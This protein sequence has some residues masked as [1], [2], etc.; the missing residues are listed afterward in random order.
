[1]PEPA[2]AAIALGS[3]LGDRAHNL[4]TALFHLATL[5]SVTAVSSFHDTAPVGY[6]DQP[7][8][9]NAAALLRTEL[10]PQ[11]LLDRLLAIEQTMGRIRT[12][13]P[14]KGPR[15]IDLDLLLYDMLVLETPT[16]TLPHPALHERLFV[17]APL[18][19]ITPDWPH[20]TLGQT[21]A[22]LLQARSSP[23]PSRPGLPASPL[24]SSPVQES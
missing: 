1:M 21:I 15:L 4:R 7:N 5:G 11:T 10:A 24:P 3:N 16:L 14:P 17:L 22:Q 9:L 2:L 23:S 13:I 6:L 8:F 12:G 20:P 19:E 18:V